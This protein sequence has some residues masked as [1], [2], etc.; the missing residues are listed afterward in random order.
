MTAKSLFNQHQGR[1]A[2]PVTL[3]IGVLMG[4]GFNGHAR[5]TP[6]VPPVQPTPS[7]VG[8]Q[9]NFE[10]VADKL[11]PT[12][13]F[14]KCQLGG[15]S[16]MDVRESGMDP[17]SPFGVPPKG[18]PREEDPRFRRPGGRP[19]EASGS[20]VIVRSDGYIL[21]ND[22][23][24]AEARRVTVRL[25]DGR[26]F[27][28][29][30]MRDFRS[31]LAVIKIDAHDLPTAEFADSDRVQIGQWAIAFGSP[32]GLTDTMTTGIVSSAHRQ[33]AIGNGSEGRFYASLLQT[34]ASIN[35]GNSGGPLVDIYGRIIGINV[36]IESPSGSS[37][38]IG[39]AIPS[40]TAR[41]VVDQLISK[42]TV[43]RGFLGMAP[44]TPTYADKQRC[45]VTQGALVQSVNPGTPAEQAGLRAG[46]MIVRYN[47]ETVTDDAQLRDLVSRTAPGQQVEIVVKR[48]HSLHTLRATVTAAPETPDAAP[49]APSAPRAPKLPFD[50]SDPRD[51]L[52]E[53]NHQPEEDR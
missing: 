38:G 47:G 12:I 21:T 41:Y 42:G 2:L 1:A 33:E 44:V 32:F 45:E 5:S 17:D 8:I 39:F 20:G 53:R 36:A 16:P 24:V 18:D 10:Q 22:H 43:T 26:E 37:A 49:K 51:W 9:S 15:R 30:V 3:A 52:R 6:G 29:R 46:D 27:E 50:P 31:D 4:L 25:Q 13:V 48:D 40:N 35:P 11:R 23:V 7:A 34:D 28:G 19:A 14:I